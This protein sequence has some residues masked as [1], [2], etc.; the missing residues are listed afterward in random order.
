MKTAVIKT[1]G[2]QYVVTEG[3][4]ITVEKLLGKQP[5]DSVSF[6]VLLMDSGSETHIGAPLLNEKAKGTVLSEGR[7]EKKIVV[8][9]KPKSRYFKKRGHRQPFSRVKIDSL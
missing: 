3:K 2:K 1:G 8:K 9:Y 7:A 5:G 4:E 6:D